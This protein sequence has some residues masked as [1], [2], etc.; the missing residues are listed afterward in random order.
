MVCIVGKVGCSVQRATD[1]DRL[2]LRYAWQAVP[3][4]RC[5]VTRSG[6]SVCFSVC[7]RVQPQ[8]GRP[9]ERIVERSW[10][11]G[12]CGLV[13]RDGR[14]RSTS[15]CWANQ[16]ATVSPS[17]TLCGSAGDLATKT[18]DLATKRRGVD[19]VA[20][21]GTSVSDGFPASVHPVSGRVLPWR[22]WAG[23]SLSQPRARDTFDGERD[24]LTGKADGKIRVEPPAEPPCLSSPAA[25]ALLTLL[26]NLM[27]GRTRQ[28]TGVQR[29]KD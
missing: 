1:V 19:V 27:A 22:C 15:R 28:Q 21:S 20:S 12:A 25:W 17:A 13:Q 26:R 14:M 11:A 16:P 7:Q 29:W 8:A 6:R 5:R 23:R 4:W 24:S 18:G 3:S 10:S 2:I 9:Y